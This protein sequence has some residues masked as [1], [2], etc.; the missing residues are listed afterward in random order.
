M[1]YALIE[2]LHRYVFDNIFI[3]KHKNTLWDDIVLWLYNK[4][5][6]KHFNWRYDLGTYRKTLVRYD[7]DYDRINNK[8]RY[9]TETSKESTQDQNT[10]TAMV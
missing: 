1:K 6:K 2:S 8:E 7:L 5:T 3:Q 10:D 4:I 9:E